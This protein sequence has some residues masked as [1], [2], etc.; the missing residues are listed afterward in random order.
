[1]FVRETNLVLIFCYLKHRKLVVVNFVLISLLNH[2]NT[3]EREDDGSE[4]EVGEENDEDED[5]GGA[6]SEGLAAREDMQ[7]V[8]RY[9]T[10]YHCTLGQIRVGRDLVLAPLKT[11]CRG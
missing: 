9:G 6:L 1:M 3:V 10:A 4:D 5:H 2:G 7:S 11:H 8:S